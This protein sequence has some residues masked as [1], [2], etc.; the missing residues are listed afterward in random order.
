MPCSRS[1]APCSR[2]AA[3]QVPARCGWETGTAPG[4]SYA[5][6]STAPP[7][8][9]WRTHWTSGRTGC[10]ASWPA[11]AGPGYAQTGTL[12]T[13][14]A[15][16]WLT[17]AGMK[18]T[19]LGYPAT[20]PSLGLLAHIRAVLAIRLWLESGEAYQEGQ[21]WWRSERR[22]RAA[23]GNPAASVH[24]PDAEIHWPSLDGSPYPDQIWAIEAELTAEPLA[25]TA[26]ILQNLLARTS[27][28]GP[29]APPG[30]TARYARVIY[31]TAWP[32][33]PVVTRAVNAVR[34]TGPPGRDPATCPKEPPGERLVLAAA[35]RH[36]LAAPPNWAESGALRGG[37]GESGGYCGRGLGRPRSGSSSGR[38]QR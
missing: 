30:R 3:A 1:Q 8:T 22:I 6:T 26:G 24:V 31:L 33:T 11:G 2:S 20:R 37:K 34:A 4:S 15:W 16:C 9:S 27:D 23:T 13:G 5:A 38:D 7:M 18:A 29:G 35:H 36:A 10:A 21:A 19:G 25:R 28:Y 17:A 14:P 32:A 12:A